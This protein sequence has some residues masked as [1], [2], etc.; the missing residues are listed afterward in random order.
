M[1]H[2]DEEQYEQLKN[3]FDDETNIDAQPQKEENFEEEEVE[4][5]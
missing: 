2:S 1:I 4:E 3:K 5:K